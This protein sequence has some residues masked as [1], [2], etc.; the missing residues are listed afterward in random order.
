MTEFERLTAMAR[1]L[2]AELETAAEDDREGIIRQL[3]EIRVRF[4]D[5][6]RAGL[7]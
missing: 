3:D 4:D 2:E 6:M 1:R 7:A 5:L